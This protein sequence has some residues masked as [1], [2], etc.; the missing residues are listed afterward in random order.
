M[1]LEIDELKEENASLKTK[2]ADSPKQEHNKEMLQ[3]L[4]EE[5]QNA[6]LRQL[7]NSGKVQIPKKSDAITKEKHDGISKK[8]HTPPGTSTSSQESRGAKERVQHED[9]ATSATANEGKKVEV[10]APDIKK[11]E[12]ADKSVSNNKKAEAAEDYIK[13]ADIIEY[14]KAS[15]TLNNQKANGDDIS[16]RK[17]KN[18][19]VERKKLPTHFLVKGKSRESGHVFFS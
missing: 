7:S 17:D 19:G 2:L 10:A 5:K 13:K 3:C 4:K 1:T 14:A 15:S 9:I 8:I 16:R 12:S 6:K 18:M 11:A